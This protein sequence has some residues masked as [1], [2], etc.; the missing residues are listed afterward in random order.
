VLSGSA[1]HQVGDHRYRLTRGD[2]FV[3]NRRHIHG[4]EDPHGLN[5]TNILIR[6]DFFDRLTS[7][8]ATVPGYHALFTISAAAPRSTEFESRMHLEEDDL[9]TSIEMD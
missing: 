9:R 5:I 1:L 3:I 8:F 2:I 6:E 7:S 4:Y